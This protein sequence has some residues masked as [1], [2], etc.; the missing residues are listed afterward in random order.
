MASRVL[1]WGNGLGVLIPM[2]AARSLGL[3]AGSEI[4]LLVLE[5]EIRI[6]AAGDQT[7]RPGTPLG[8]GPS[9]S[10]KVRSLLERW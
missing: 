9:H 5:D 6:R 4:R 3:K 8:N 2:F 1:K 10:E 7:A